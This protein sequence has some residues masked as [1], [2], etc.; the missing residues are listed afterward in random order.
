M[1]CTN[2]ISKIAN[3]SNNIRGGLV[4]ELT[5]CAKKVQAGSL[6]LASI[7]KEAGEAN[8]VEK[9]PQ[10]VQNKM[11]ELERENNSLKKCIEELRE[12]MHV[13]REM[14][15]S[16]DYEDRKKIKKMEREM[17]ELKEEKEKMKREMDEMR[18]EK[19]KKE[20]RQPKR[21]KTKQG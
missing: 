19:G 1:D 18:A 7:I 9:T 12:Q 5:I 11:E 10:K 16:D 20:P 17:N 13:V 4:R 15:T 6:Q 8:T 2:R 14:Y 21:N 3:C